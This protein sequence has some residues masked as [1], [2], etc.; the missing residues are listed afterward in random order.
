MS[1]SVFHTNVDAQVIRLERF[2]SICN[3]IVR[4]PALHDTSSAVHTILLA[5]ILKM[6]SA[7]EAVRVLANSCS[8]EEILAIGHTML[9][10]V[11]NAAF[12]QHASEK[13]VERY[14]RFR[15]ETNNRIALRAPTQEVS[16]SS[17]LR[18]FRD[19]I[20]LNLPGSAKEEIPA[21]SRMS[22]RDRAQ[23]ADDASDIPVMGLLVARCSAR[24]QAAVRGTMGSLDYFV[25]ALTN[26]P[27][28]QPENRLAALTEAL[29]GVNLCLFTFAFYLSSYF[30]LGLDRMIEGAV[31]VQAPQLQR[32]AQQ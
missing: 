29:S 27:E 3:D 9:E 12:L 18:R 25:S 11:V 23:F 31:N 32:S 7:G 2:I 24:G 21:W 14:M 6:V 19:S 16:A 13:E 8:V 5:S 1:R 4:N 20:L 26:S 15:P 28:A 22:L 10:V 30:N 17:A